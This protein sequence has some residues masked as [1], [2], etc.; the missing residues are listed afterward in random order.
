MGV[1]DLLT[2]LAT[3]VAAVA[4]LAALLWRARRRG[5]AE[6]RERRLIQD[7]ARADATRRRMDDAEADLGNDPDALRDWL[8]QRGRE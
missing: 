8:R 6:E 1:A 2:L 7:R 3:A 4:G 5:A